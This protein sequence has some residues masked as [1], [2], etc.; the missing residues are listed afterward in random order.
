MPVIVAPENWQSW[1]SGMPEDVAEMVA[2]YRDGE[3]QG[4]P[5]SW[6]VNK[7][8]DDDEGLIERIEVPA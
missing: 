3:L 6:R 2:P 8:E 1:L 4:W 5:V 7:T